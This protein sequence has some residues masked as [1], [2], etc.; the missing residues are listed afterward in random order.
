MKNKLEAL[1]IQKKYTQQTVAEALSL[2]L[3]TYRQYE[4]CERKMKPE[5]LFL[6]ADFYDV[7]IDEILMHR[8]PSRYISVS[9]D[10][11][12]MLTRYESL[13][14]RDKHLIRVMLEELSV[15]DA[16][17]ISMQKNPDFRIANR[18]SGTDSELPS[19]F[20]KLLEDLPDVPED[21]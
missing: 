8:L 2:P 10:E 3:S 18:S 21:T 20:L 5:T 14:E 13:T 11:K 1:R 12:K 9:A 15:P 7:T 17:S 6:V 16:G 4:K 19:D